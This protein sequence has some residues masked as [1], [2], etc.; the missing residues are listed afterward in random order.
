MKQISDKITSGPL[1]QPHILQEGV[2]IP[3][4]KVSFIIPA[5][6]EEDTIGIVLKELKDA[7]SDQEILVIDDAS[8]D[9]TFKT[10]EEICPGK[11]LKH[12]R[13]R[14]Y[15]AALKT[16]VLNTAGEFVIFIDGDGQ[17]SIE[18]IKKIVDAIN[19]N[20]ELDSVLTERRNIYASGAVRS[21]GK[22][23]INHTIKR[24]THERIKDSNSGLR[25][26]KRMKLYPFLFMMPNGFSFSTTSTVLSYKE[27]F[28]LQWIEIN[29]KER[30]YGKSQVKIRHGFDTLLLIIRL[31][32][33]FDPL[34]FFLP[35]TGASLLL[36]CISIINAVIT[37]GTL[38]KN[39][40]FFFIFG[41]LMF[42]LGLLSE[43]IST[44]RK[45]ISSIRAKD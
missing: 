21:L 23:L 2:L 40:I 33:I 36:G 34:K 30:K 10:A 6:N 5:Y 39:Y 15:G 38:G 24:L 41:V 35:L 32:V 26:F 43:Q 37:S 12:N 16:G 42:I 28:N 13:N 31:I 17:H 3:Q 8:T 18:D 1:N 4:V 19:K 29:M 7:F 20:P 14:G 25:A 9:D 11:V 44:L 22:L 27:D 45:E